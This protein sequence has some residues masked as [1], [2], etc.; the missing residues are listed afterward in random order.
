MLITVNSLTELCSMQ[1]EELNLL[2][3]YL[4][5]I[6][7]FL[8]FKKAAAAILVVGQFSTFD[9]NDLEG[10]VIPLFGWFQGHGIH[11]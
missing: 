4:C 8:D 11:F 9:L 5:N 1:F 3:C 10:R 2:G 6:E 7:H